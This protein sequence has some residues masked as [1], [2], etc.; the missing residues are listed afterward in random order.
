MKL[1]DA[2]IIRP[3]AEQML[4][5]LNILPEYQTLQTILN[6]TFDDQI[7]TLINEIEKARLTELAQESDDITTSRMILRPQA[8]ETASRI[9][10]TPDVTVTQG[11]PLKR[12]AA[13]I[14][15]LRGNAPHLSPS[16]PFIQI[17]LHL[18]AITKTFAEI[19]AI[20]E[21]NFQTNAVILKTLCQTAE[22]LFQSLG[23]MI[24]EATIIMKACKEFALIH[25]TTQSLFDIQA[26]PSNLFAICTSYCKQYMQYRSDLETQHLY[27][28]LFTCHLSLLQDKLDWV[29]LVM[30]CV[31]TEHEKIAAESELEKLKSQGPAIIKAQASLKAAETSLREATERVI[32]ATNPDIKAAATEWQE[33]ARVEITS[34]QARAKMPP[35]SQQTID[36]AELFA[37]NAKK[38]FESMRTTAVNY[39]A[40]K[41]NVR[42]AQE[43]SSRNPATTHKSSNQIT[44]V[45]PDLSNLSHK[46]PRIEY[47]EVK[48]NARLDSINC[49]IRDLI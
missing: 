49:Q 31:L 4:A 3:S 32:A 9:D 42:E 2:L 40:H 22:N 14:A 7:I 43:L 39:A 15:S 47:Q 41:K 38:K 23:T 34:F 37:T 20:S 1:R 5:N 33:R 44:V 10:S 27:R 36:Q 35:P 12:G 30:S 25:N 29:D 19:A 13:G 16:S 45:S 11:S 46:V 6:N 48:L 17:K 24:N 18:Q 8:V 28:E 21:A 26:L